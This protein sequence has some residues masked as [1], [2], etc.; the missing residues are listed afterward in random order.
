MHHR[1]YI[2]QNPLERK[3]IDDA[4]TYRYCSA[5]PGFKLDSWPPAAKA[6]IF[7]ATPIGTSGTRALPDS[8]KTAADPSLRSGRRLQSHRVASLRVTP[9]KRRHFATSYFLARG[10]IRETS[11]GS[12]SNFGSS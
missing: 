6:A 11:T 2:H 5:F 12:N 7:E 1:N 9:A 8:P 4:G 3:M 10:G